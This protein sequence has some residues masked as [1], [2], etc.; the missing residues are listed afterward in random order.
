MTGVAVQTD[1]LTLRRWCDE[2]REPFA[3]LNADP[4]V[5]EFLPALLTRAQSDAMVDRIEQTWDECGL[6]LFAVEVRDT[7]DF[8]GYI[9]LWPATFEAPFTPAI[10]IGWRLARA[11]WGHGYATE[12]ASAALADGFERLELGEIVSFTAVVNE[13]SQRVMERLGMTRD[14]TEDF[15]HPALVEGDRLRR[16]VLYRVGS[17]PEPTK[18]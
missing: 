9:G 4:V 18:S 15:D 16:H 5:M 12:G 1:R 2:D 17:T 11:Y 10:E 6:G 3:A 7:G 14:P 13:P 8:A